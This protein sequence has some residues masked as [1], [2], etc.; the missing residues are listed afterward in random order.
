MSAEL[1]YSLISD[2]DNERATSQMD[3]LQKWRS[4]EKSEKYGGDSGT[5]YALV[6]I[7]SIADSV[8]LPPFVRERA[9]ELYNKA[10]DADLIRGHSIEA[11][12]CACVYIVSHEADMPRNLGEYTSGIR[13]HKSDVRTAVKYL[14][15]EL[16][17]VRMEPST[18]DDHIERFVQKVNEKKRRR[19]E[20]DLLL[21]ETLVQK[22]NEMLEGIEH[23]S[24]GKSPTVFAGAVIYAAGKVLGQNVYQNEIADVAD[25]SQ[26]AIR[27]RYKEIIDEWEGLHPEDFA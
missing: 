17:G 21:E 20:E 7:E 19:G 23:L 9:K 16:E 12:A 18:P 27:E 25:I 11:V 14:A 8:E 22:S 15:N 3:A 4:E 2:D 24:Y 10:H 5:E 26:K 13:V 1:E 6:K